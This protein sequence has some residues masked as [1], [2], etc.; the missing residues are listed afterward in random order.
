MSDNKIKFGKTVIEKLATTEKTTTFWDSKDTG[1]GVRVQPSGAKTFFFQGRSKGKL[2]KVTI[3]R[4]GALTVEQARDLAKQHAADL[5]RGIDPRT[6]RQADEEQASFGDMLTAYIE[7]L[8]S[9]KKYDARA[10]E[11]TIEKNIEKAFP[12]LYKKVATEI[13]LDDC[14][15][16]V[17]KLKDEGKSRQADKVRSYIRTAFSEAINARGNVSASK[18][19]RDIKVTYNPAREL[20]IVDGSNN[21]NDRVLEKSEFMA[22]WSRLKGLPEPYRSVAMLHVLTGG[23]RLRQL[24]RATLN[25]IDM[26]SKTLTLW[27]SKG[28]RKTARRHVIPLLDV[29]IECIKNLTGSGEYILSCNGGLSPISDTYLGNIAKK[30]NAEME[31]SGE[32]IKG[33]FTPKHIRA[34]IETRLADRPYRIGSDVLGQLES[35]GT[36]GVQ[37]R[38]YQRYDYFEE[39][40]D[41]LEKLYRL[42]EGLPEPQAQVVDIRK[43][44]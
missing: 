41:A 27:D 44:V 29:T 5:T 37:N 19:L 40:L 18:K 25:D 36:G 3:G 1:F 26:T 6:K 21:T 33:T 8:Y 17:G 34:T 35:H 7:L 12:K 4:F 42:V 20:R 9:N 22:Y 10:V 32:L 15:K 16:I 43:A 24:S 2:I 31:D 23:Q 28:R 11:T 30:I 13:T 39:K 38:H 14:V